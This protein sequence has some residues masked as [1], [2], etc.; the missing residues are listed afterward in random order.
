MLHGWRSLAPLHAVSYADTVDSGLL[1]NTDAQ[2]TAAAD[3]LCIAQEDHARVAQAARIAVLARVANADQ[4]AALA[5]Q[6]RDATDSR[7]RVARERAAAAPPLLDELATSTDDS[8]DGTP[9]G[10]ATSSLLDATFL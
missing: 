5:Q 10:G 4:E 9:L 8:G 1:Q 2:N 6:E 3:L 7:A